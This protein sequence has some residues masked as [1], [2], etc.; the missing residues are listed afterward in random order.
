MIRSLSLKYQTKFMLYLYTRER[1]NCALRLWYIC[2]LKNYFV[3]L[4]K[5]LDNL[6]RCN[7][8]VRIIKILW[9]EKNFNYL[10]K[11]KVYINLNLRM[12]SNRWIMYQIVYSKQ[13]LLG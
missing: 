8:C 10:Q 5:W 9:E 12:K 13:Y 7:I 1:R 4:K 6:K 3:I 2:N 11:I